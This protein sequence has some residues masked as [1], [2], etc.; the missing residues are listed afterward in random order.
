MLYALHKSYEKHADVHRIQNCA[1]DCKR[2]NFD[3]TYFYHRVRRFI[4]FGFENCK[5]CHNC[6][7]N[8]ARSQNCYKCISGNKTQSHILFSEYEETHPLFKTFNPENINENCAQNGVSKMEACKSGCINRIT[9]G[10]KFKRNKNS[11]YN[12][13]ADCNSDCTVYKKGL[14]F[15]TIIGAFFRAVKQSNFIV[16]IAVCKNIPEQHNQK[17][18]NYCRRCKNSERNSKTPAKRNIRTAKNCCTD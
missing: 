11:K 9:E 6:E 18:H 5:W 12:V 14:C 7:Q 10:C 3:H 8:T 13:S 4:H 2:E 17:G 16:R 1:D 15:V